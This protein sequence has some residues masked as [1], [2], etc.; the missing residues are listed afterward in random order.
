MHFLSHYYV[1]RHGYNPY[2]VLGA[3]LPDISP[4]FTRTYNSVIRKNEWHLEGDV[5]EIHKGVLR[6]YDVD[7]QFHSS[8]Y[9]RKACADALKHMIDAGLDRDQYRL[10]F[11][12]HIAVEVMLDRQLIAENDSLV[13]EYYKLLES[14]EIDT[15][16]L[17]LSHVMPD[18]VREKTLGG[19][20]RFLEVKFLTYIDTVE[21]AA[22]GITRTGLKATGVRFTETDREKLI[23]ALHNIGN[24]LRYSWNKLLEIR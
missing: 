20:A 6:H 23:V 14:I 18:E 8:L 1:D 9:F 3:L 5:S 24:E 10:S 4:G 17:Y 12:A 22:E 21:G 16:S 13:S 7:A 19:F 11:L 15:F 2:L